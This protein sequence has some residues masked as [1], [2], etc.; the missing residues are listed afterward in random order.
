MPLLVAVSRIKFSHSVKGKRKFYCAVMKTHGVAED[1]FNVSSRKLYPPLCGVSR[2][3]PFD[4]HR[5][6]ERA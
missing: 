5:T 1:S 4:S 6:L 2:Y 3:S